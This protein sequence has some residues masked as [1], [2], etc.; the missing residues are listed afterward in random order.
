Q[1]LTQAKAGAKVLRYVAC[2]S[3]RN[4]SVRADV[5]LQQVSAGH[6]LAAIAPCDNVFVIRSDWYNDNP[7]VLKGPGAGK[8]VTAGGLHTD[9]AVLVNQ[10]TGKTK[11]PAVLT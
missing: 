5:S 4:G 8:V 6:A 2:L 9:L 10:L 11:L 1:L 7:L 3:I